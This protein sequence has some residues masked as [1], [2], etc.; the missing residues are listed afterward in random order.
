VDEKVSKLNTTIQETMKAIIP[1]R[2]IQ[3]KAWISDNTRDG[4]NQEAIKAKTTGIK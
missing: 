2:K 1:A 4:K 3:Y